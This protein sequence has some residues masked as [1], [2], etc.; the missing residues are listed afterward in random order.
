LPAQTA[1]AGIAG[2]GADP[3]VPARSIDVVAG[4]R[5]CEISVPRADRPLGRS[6]NFP[7]SVARRLGADPHALCRR[8]PAAGP[9]SGR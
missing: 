7:R 8:S 9:R 5:Q 4:V 6:D 3:A 1:H 2:T